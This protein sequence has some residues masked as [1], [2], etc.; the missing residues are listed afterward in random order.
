MLSNNLFVFVLLLE[1]VEDKC[2]LWRTGAF[3]ALKP[4]RTRMNDTRQVAGTSHDTA[5]SA[6][7]PRDAVPGKVCCKESEKFCCNRPASAGA[8]GVD[9]D[10]SSTY[11]SKSFTL[12]GITQIRH[13]IH[14]LC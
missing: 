6:G 3:I 14:T 11:S 9:K 13:C 12:S 8:L 2:G 5:V 4:G 10:E 1:S 7:L